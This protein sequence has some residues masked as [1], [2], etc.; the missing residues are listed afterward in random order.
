MLISDNA[1]APGQNQL[2][3][4]ASRN[5]T[6]FMKLYFKPEGVLEQINMGYVQRHMY[7]S[8]WTPPKHSVGSRT[9]PKGTNLLQFSLA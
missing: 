4:L 2:K 9:L 6:A 5:G 3:I 8:S 7:C 1:T